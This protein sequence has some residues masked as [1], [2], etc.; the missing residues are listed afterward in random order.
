MPY[1]KQRTK[2]GQS[3]GKLVTYAANGAANYSWDGAATAI[4]ITQAASA[5]A[6]FSLPDPVLWQVLS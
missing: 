6:N 5:N 2:L 4:S 1:L 3:E